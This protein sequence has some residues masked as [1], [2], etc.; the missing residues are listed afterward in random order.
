MTV[1]QVIKKEYTSIIENKIVYS[2]SNI[3]NGTTEVITIVNKKDNTTN[4]L[5]QAP[6]K[7]DT[8][9]PE[10]KLTAAVIPQVESKD[11]IL[12]SSLKF[13]KDNYPQFSQS[14]FSM[15]ID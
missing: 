9:I 12:K 13:V 14:P 1:E 11:D 7:N 5:E 15:T 8:E 4:V 3:T 2:S 6:Y 10:T